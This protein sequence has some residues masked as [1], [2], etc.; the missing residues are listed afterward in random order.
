MA[1]DQKDRNI[2]DESNK[3]SDKKLKDEQGASFTRR[4]ILQMG[5]SVPA[6][7]GL[8]AI[9][10]KMADA[11]AWAD[12]PPHSDSHTDGWDSH[13]DSHSDHTD[14]NARPADTKTYPFKQVLLQDVTKIREESKI[15]QGKLNMAQ[16][17]QN[18]SGISLMKLKELVQ[19]LSAKINAQAKQSGTGNLQ[20]LSTGTSNAIIIVNGL[21]QKMGAKSKYSS[22]ELLN[23]LD[24]LLT[25]LEADIKS[26]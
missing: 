2:P 23:Q 16:E 24:K 15:L 3:E 22:L 5:W 14:A 20:K 4:Q 7:F 17:G 8:A 13:G 10:P 6:A 1:E 25:G 18:L 26:L 9:F 12:S 19:A 11:G 21:E